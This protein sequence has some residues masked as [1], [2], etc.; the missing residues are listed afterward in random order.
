LLTRGNTTPLFDD[1]KFEV[2]DT[3]NVTYRL[4][5]QTE[6]AVEGAISYNSS[7]NT[8]TFDP[9]S[10]LLEYTDYF[11]LITTGAEDL[12]GNGLT[13]DYFWTFRTINA[14]LPTIT[15]DP[16]NSP[17]NLDYQTVNGTMESG[18]TIEVT[19]PTAT[20]GTVTYP[21][22]TTWSVEITGMTEGDNVITATATDQLGNTASDT[23][24]IVLDLPSIISVTP[25]GL[26]ALIGLLS[27][28]AVTTIRGRQK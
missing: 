27:V 2:E 8:V 17:T 5:R 1:F 9:V 15:I 10:N 13:E 22:D 26:I 4:I 21:T 16:V 6:I 18:A 24:T 3:T 25:I 28:I 12:A 20:I 7:S 19:C 14:T 23:A 11:P